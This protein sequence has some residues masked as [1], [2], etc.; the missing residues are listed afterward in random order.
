[1]GCFVRLA[2]ALLLLTCACAHSITITP[3]LDALPAPA[4]ARI[5]KNVGYYIAPENLAKQVETPGGGGDKVKYL[6]YKE[7]EPAL[8]QVLSNIFGEVHALPSPTA[9]ELI[10]SKNIAYVF[11]PTI[12]TDSSSRSSWIWPPSDFTVSLDCRAT[13]GTGKVIWET[14]L[15]TEAHMRLPDVYRD[16]SLAGKEAIKE[17]FLELQNRI[18]KSGEFR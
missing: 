8:K 7:S 4:G 13:D 5:E 14:S 10:A 6:P 9:A 18:V 17:A 16:H 3:G 11:I 2:P 12:T 15:K 1:M